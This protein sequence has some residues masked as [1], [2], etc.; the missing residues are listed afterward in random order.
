MILAGDIGGTFQL[1][2]LQVSETHELTLLE[3]SAAVGGRAR[4]A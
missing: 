4:V 3:D 2:R 1:F